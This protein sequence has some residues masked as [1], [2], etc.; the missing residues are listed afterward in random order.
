MITEDQLEELCIDWFKELGWD[1]ECGYDIAPDSDNPKRKDYKEVIIKERLLEGLT[2]INPGI[3]AEVIE[4][5]A[6]RISRPESPILIVNNRQ[7]HRYINNGVPVDLRIGDRVKGDFVKLID[8]ENIENNNFLV[9]NQFTINGK[10]GNRR[11]DLVVFINGL[12]VSVIE[13][14][15]AADE[16]ADIWKAY[17]QTITYKEELPDL[18]AYNVATIISDGMNARIGSITSGKE[19]Y[20]YWRTIRTE[21][22]R[23]SFEFELEVM[24]RGFFNRELLLDYIRYF[25]I[26]EE[27]AGNIIKKIAGYHQFHAVREAIAS[28]IAATQDIKDGKCGV[29]WHTQGSGKSI[30]MSCYATKL[31]NH[32]RMNNPTL[33][34]VTD[35][36]DLD[37]QLYDTFCNSIELLREEPE[38]AD[39]RD[40]LRKLLNRPAG[41]IIFTTIQKFSLLDGEEHFPMLTNRSNVVVISDE[42]HRSQ[43]GLKA[44]VR[45]KDGKMTYGYAKHLRDALPNAGFIGFTGTPVS[46]EDR[47]TIGVFGDYVSVY[48]IEQAVKDKAT[49]PIY[50]ES[51]LAELQL[52]QKASELDEE[53]DEIIEKSEDAN[54]SYVNEQKTKWAALEKLVTAES[55]VKQ[56]AKNLVEHWEDRL[57]TID[58]KAMIVCIS[59]DACVQMYKEI[60]ALRPQWAGSL[61]E[62]GRPSIN[63]GV[64]RVV[65][66]G[67]A[68]DKK[69]L[70]E[71]VY[72]KRG[73]KK[74]ESRC[75][76]EKDPLKIVIVRDMWLTGFD[77]PMM[78]T[79]YIDK[80]MRGAN[81]MQAIARVNRV[82]K[83][84]PGG[85]VVDYLGITNELREALKTYT[86]SQGK[87]KPTIDV[88]EALGVLEGKIDY[89]RD[90][91]SGVD[92][93]E[94]KN[95]KKIFSIIAEACDHLLKTENGSKDFCD[96]TLAITQ[97]NALCGTMP[98]AIVYREEIA[99]F[100]TIKAALTK[101]SNADRKISDD[102]VQNALR[103][104]VSKA[105]ASDKIV[106]IFEAAGL[107]SPDISILSD[108]FLEEVKNLKQ[109]NLAVE[110]LSRLLKGEVKSKTATNIVQAKKYSDL[111]TNALLKYRNRSIETA[112]II[113]ELIQMAKDFK[114]EMG[115]GKDLGLNDD[116]L[117]FYDALANDEAAMREL[118]DEILK[119]IAHELTAELR[120]TVTVDWAKRES[121]RASIRIKIKR[122]LRKYK[123]PPEKTDEAIALVLQQAETLSES[124]VK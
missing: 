117:A 81:L 65:M 46:Q 87:G 10:N 57:N 93:T 34:V 96:V 64:V 60:T 98:E 82:F 80:P 55:R 16:N 76:D 36:N 114:K 75:K 102:Q 120:N 86:Q 113:E 51:R 68:S 58:G 28:T 11:P 106:D 103:Q 50:Y 89:A 56:V 41:G 8:F 33:V 20:A 66:T 72:D 97:A 63:D 92:Y 123:Y 23:P 95:P 25:V 17:E 12:P 5:V 18:F 42:A 71:H 19:R 22:D 15:N 77:A 88:Y 124:W 99:F 111:L 13:L 31:M 90:M 108:S 43:Y 61:D 39:S 1:Y 27:N 70:R 112:Q 4:E 37:G 83:D 40:E 115:R 38:Q 52:T 45:A 14:K 118:G 21:K 91:L 122:L 62:N 109:K 100:Q 78:H 30:S 44:K 101:K 67:S 9:I 73:R 121:V 7:F 26:F 32:P 59:R 48:D 2:K 79:M 74:L 35:R 53:V 84:K 107:Q 69:E 105:L 110:M 49:V 29:V 54:D 104:V 116:E 6:T 119:A 85:L 47:D 3:P 94:F 24:I